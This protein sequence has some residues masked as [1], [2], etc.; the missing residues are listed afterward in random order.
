MN[1]G[2]GIKIG[3]AAILSTAAQLLGGW[4]TAL[5]TLILFMAVDYI[6]GLV[7]AAVF[8][9]SPK[10]E[11]GALESKAGF[12]GLFRKGAV[13]LVV[14]VG[15]R[16]DVM[17]GTGELVRNATIIGFAVSELVS[18][19]ENIGLMGVDLPPV[20]TQAIDILKKKN[21]EVKLP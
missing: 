20:I 13:L 12:K 7:V 3:L 8:K 9:T 19:L 4:D 6:T 5:Q 16:L 2:N 14:L 15:T 10:T 17:I 21:D 1:T 18:I 11:T